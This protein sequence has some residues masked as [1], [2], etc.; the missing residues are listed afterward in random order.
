MK[1]DLLSPTR[2]FFLFEV[3]PLSFACE[4]CKLKIRAYVRVYIKFKLFDQLSA[5]STEKAM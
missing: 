3:T 2:I 1:T 5:R 4:I